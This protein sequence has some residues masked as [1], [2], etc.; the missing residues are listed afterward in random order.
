MPNKRWRLGIG[1]RAHFRFPQK[2]ASVLINAFI[3]S[4]GFSYACTRVNCVAFF[5]ARDDLDKCKDLV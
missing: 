3:D 2:K 5:V 1:C 4:K